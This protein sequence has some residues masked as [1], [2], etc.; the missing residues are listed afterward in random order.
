M[1]LVINKWTKNWPTFLNGQIVT[2][3]INY[4][5]DEGKYQSIRQTKLYINVVCQDIYGNNSYEKIR[6]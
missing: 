2:Q 4:Q 6:I 3:G 1:V 5:Q